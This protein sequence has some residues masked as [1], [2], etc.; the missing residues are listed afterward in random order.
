MRKAGKLSYLTYSICSVL[1]N[2]STS[3]PESV[4]SPN[5]DAGQATEARGMAWGFKPASRRVTKARGRSLARLTQLGA[6][7]CNCSCRC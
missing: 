7:P 4:S 6:S 5:V 1:C 2:V 3:F